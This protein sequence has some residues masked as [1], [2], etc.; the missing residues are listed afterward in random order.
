MQL[1]LTIP[2]IKRQSIIISDTATLTDFAR[3][4][5][6]KTG[7]RLF[8]GFGLTN[9]VGAQPNPVL[10]VESAISNL[11]VVSPTGPISAGGVALGFAGSGYQIGDVLTLNQSPTALD[12][13]YDGAAYTNTDN[14]TVT[15]A[16]IATV[17]GVAGTIATFTQ[18]TN[19]TNY[20]TTDAGGYTGPSIVNGVT[21]LPGIT[22]VPATGGHGTG[23]T[24]LITSVTNSIVTFSGAT[25]ATGTLTVGGTFAAGVVLTATIG[26][27][28]VSYTTQAG[29][30]N[31]NGIAASLAAAIN[32]ANV[33]VKAVA[34]S[35]VITLTSTGG[36]NLTLTATGTGVTVTASG[37]TLT[38][39]VRNDYAAPLSNFG[40]TDQDEIQCWN[41]P[42][43]GTGQPL[44]IY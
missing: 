20:K 33:G 11:T 42:L 22:G 7:A 17:N 4:A 40:I 16:S 31:L 2:G 35:A 14:A 15:V 23:A 38:G 9:K 41:N 34:A 44:G 8:Q 10:P 5:F 19:G 1:Y 24:F 26:G 6:D 28:L 13:N 12:K 43:G 3:E 37:G 29:D 32:T 30:T 21:Q 36:F 27:V 25:N 18:T 39:G